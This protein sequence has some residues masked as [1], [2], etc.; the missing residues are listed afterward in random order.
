MSKLLEIRVKNRQSIYDIA[1][2]Y[3]GAIEGIEPLLNDNRA[4]L[5]EGLNTPLPEGKILKIRT[6]EP[7]DE[8]VVSRLTDD[9]REPATGIKSDELPAGGDY[10][11]DYTNDYTI[12]P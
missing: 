3:Y 9:Q 6:G 2:S 5:P 4:D 8:N 1:I 10:N 11:T 7:V 12:A